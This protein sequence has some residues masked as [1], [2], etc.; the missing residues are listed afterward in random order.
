MKFRMTLILAML[1]SAT[2]RTVPGQSAPLKDNPAS[3]GSGVVA[4]RVTGLGKALE[5]AIVRLRR[6][7]QVITPPDPNEADYTTTTSSTGS[8]K[9]EGVS[10]GL[11]RVYADLPGWIRRYH[12]SRPRGAHFGELIRVSS[13]TTSA[14][15]DIDLLPQGKISGRVQDRAGK[16]LAGVEV[17]ALMTTYEGAHKFSFPMQT[18]Q[19]DVEG[20][21]ST[22]NLPPGN[23]LLRVASFSGH[24]V[25]GRVVESGRPAER[26]VEK[27]LLRTTY[28]PAA[29]MME[30]A[31]KL[32]LDPGSDLEGIDIKADSVTPFRICGAVD[33]G[34]LTLPAFLVL[35]LVT[36]EFDALA[37]TRPN[38]A[39]VQPDGTFCFEEVIPGDYYL[40]PARNY[41]SLKQNSAVAGSS[42][43]S[44][45]SADSGPLKFVAASPARIEGRIVLAV[46]SLAPNNA[47]PVQPLSLQDRRAPQSAGA[48]V[49]PPPN[50][51]PAPA[52]VDPAPPAN[53]LGPQ[54]D[55]AAAAPEEITSLQNIQ[56]ELQVLGRLFINQ[57]R[58]MS[59]REGKFLVERVAVAKYSVRTRNLPSGLYVQSVLWNGTE[60]GQ[61]GFEP[62]SDGNLTITLSRDAKSIHG[63]VKNPKSEPIP[64]SVVSLWKEEGSLNEAKQ[65]FR[66]IADSTGRFSFLNLA[67][68]RYR[69]LASSEEIDPSLAENP[70]YCLAFERDAKQVVLDKTQTAAE[71]VEL[72]ELP[73]ATIRAKGW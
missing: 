49:A 31:N 40:E 56:V 51:P 13:D 20:N 28:H 22:R 30:A 7:T 9:V 70:F 52:A 55:V 10:A 65:I 26:P 24:R 58:E 59:D 50:A 23:Y 16:P 60:I 5:G 73:M 61:A 36:T 8:Y 25:V 43:V 54:A 33:S 48:V 68:G 29:T 15:V 4:G 66:S 1:F 38:L 18:V 21:Y 19:T 46:D 2:A 71:N 64:G 6:E 12:G 72:I 63:I 42:V 11:F 14:G 47:K 3:S 17:S 44:I 62:L 45:K 37:T 41:V 34:R 53:A 32:S 27:A 69:L 35:A 57:P 39:Q 67:P